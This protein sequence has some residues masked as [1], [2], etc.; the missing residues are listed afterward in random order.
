MSK[1]LNKQENDYV[2][3]LVAGQS[4]RKAYRNAFKQ[5]KRWKDE[6]VD[7]KASNLLRQDK[8]QTR[9]REL[10]KEAKDAS[11]NMAIWSRE[12]A[13]A[14]YEWLKDKAKEE[15]EVE[16]VKH[17]PSQ[18][19]LGAIEGMNQMAF[20]D[21]ELADKKLLAEI[22]RIEAEAKIKEDQADKL[23][24]SGKAFDLLESLYDVTSGGDGSGRS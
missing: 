6:T 21:L 22:R 10:L 3:F 5:S 2:A 23:A 11:S 4:Q 16:G 9:Y 20:I 7:S 24:A 14:E 13:F 15:I 17:A 12:Q 1:E 19:F 18:A 8:V